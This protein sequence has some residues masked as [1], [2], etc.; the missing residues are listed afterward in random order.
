MNERDDESRCADNRP[1]K[2]TVT[3]VTIR[4]EHGP[5]QGRPQLNA[6]VM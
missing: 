4:A 5:R 3:P 2:L 6:G 1:L